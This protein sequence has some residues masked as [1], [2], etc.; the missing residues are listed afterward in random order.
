[1]SAFRRLA[2]SKLKKILNDWKTFIANIMAR[3]F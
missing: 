1:M 3:N 2:N